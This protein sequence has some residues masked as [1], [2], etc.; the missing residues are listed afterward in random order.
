MSGN[1]LEQAKKGAKGFADDAQTK[2]YSVGL[3][4]FDTNAQHLLEPQRHLHQVYRR[5]PSHSV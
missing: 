4:Q 3:I 1:K 5:N 2:G